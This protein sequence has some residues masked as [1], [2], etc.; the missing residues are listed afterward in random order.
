MTKTTKAVT[1]GLP[2]FSDCRFLG[3]RFDVK[4]QKYSTV[5]TIM[6]PR[7]GAIMIPHPVRPQVLP[8]CLEIPEPMP[9]LPPVNCYYQQLEFTPIMRQQVKPGSSVDFQTPRAICNRV[10]TG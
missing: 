6:F 1:L 8:T 3:C 2:Q 7:G 10:T 4:G 9:Y 5:S